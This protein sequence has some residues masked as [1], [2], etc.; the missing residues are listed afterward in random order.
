VV[1]TRVLLWPGGRLRVNYTC[2]ETGELTVR[3]SDP[4]RKVIP[5][6]D[7]GDC[8]S[9]KGDSTGQLVQWRD[10]ELDE[11][12]GKN[13]RLEFFIRNCDLYSFRSAER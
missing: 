5:G 4:S 6:F 12:K 1:C 9:L 11:L 8:V 10:A 3:V 13:L 2:D 7:H